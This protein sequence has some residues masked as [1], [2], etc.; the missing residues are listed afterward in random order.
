MVG[1]PSWLRNLVCGPRISELEQEIDD[2]EATIEELQPP[3]YPDI[4]YDTVARQELETR[5]GDVTGW[6]LRDEH[7]WLDS[8]YRL[9]TKDDF[10]EYTLTVI[11]E[12]PGYTDEFFDCEDFAFSFMSLLAQRM[13]V[14]GVGTIIS[15]PPEHHAFNVVVCQDTIELWEPNGAAYVTDSDEQKYDLDGAWWLI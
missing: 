15:P 7:Y 11:G 14:N 9:P 8:Q 2:L 3:E 6:G 1:L 10:N 5:L 4:A 13:Q 12:L